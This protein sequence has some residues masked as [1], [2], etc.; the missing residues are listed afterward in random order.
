MKQNLSLLC[1][2]YEFTM[3]YGYLKSSLAEKICYFDVYFRQV[4]DNGGFVIAAGL[5][6]IVEFVKNLHFDDEDI[7]F[8]RQKGLFDEQFLA[9]LKDFKFSGDIWAVREGE[10]VFANEPILTVR[11]KAPQAQLL[12]TFILLSLNHQSLIATK[13][14]RVVRAALNRAVFNNTQN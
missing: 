12:E 14:S 1:D 7:E 13:T 5:E 10:I 4:P 9:Y 8:F 6:Q 3:S 2:F 11:A